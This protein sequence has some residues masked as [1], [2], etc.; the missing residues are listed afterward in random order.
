MTNK[1]FYRELGSIDPKMIEAAAPAEM[2]QK[3]KRNTW[4]KLAAIA[5]CLALILGAVIVVPMWRDDSPDVTTEAPTTAGTVNTETGTT[6]K[7]Y[8][9]YLGSSASVDAVDIKNS[10]DRVSF[11]DA[12]Q[13]I[14]SF[15]RDTIFDNSALVGTTRKLNI[16]DK[17][18]SLTYSKSYRTKLYS[19]EKFK[20]YAEFITF[21]ADDI[22]VYYRADDGAL[23]FFSD[24]NVGNLT[25]SGELTED[26]AKTLALNTIISLYGENVAREYVLDDI[27]FTDTPLTQAY[28]VVYTKYVYD[29]PT[30][31]K[32]QLS[33]NM[34]GD[35]VTVNAKLLGVYDDATDHLSQKQIDEAKAVLNEALA[36]DWSILTVTLV[37]DSLGDY[38]LKVQTAKTTANGIAATELFIGIQ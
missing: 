15:S 30:N 3:K 24:L 7:T 2:V 31:D 11:E 21:K 19:S 20:P 25:V 23:I 35:L 26:G 32:I 22:S 6:E 38:Y 1:E 28:T 17:S 8:R 18:Y 10:S 9:I 27:V 4:V 29:M 12:S 14:F 13:K 33:F 16:G 36:D 37:I 34:Q 5:A